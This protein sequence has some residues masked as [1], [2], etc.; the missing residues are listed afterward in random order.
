MAWDF[1][2]QVLRA[3]GASPEE[4]AEA[5]S[6]LEALIR[7]FT[8]THPPTPPR[9]LARS[10]FAYLWHTYPRRYLSGGEFRLGRVIENQLRPG[11]GPVGNC[12]GLTLLYNALAGG[13]GLRAGAVYLEEAF[14]H[15]P[16]TLSL[17]S[18]STGTIDIENIFP[19]GFDYPGH[20]DNP[21]REVWGEAEL[22]AEV[23]TSVGNGLLEAGDLRGAVDQ[24]DRALSLCPTFYKALV[25]RAIALGRLKGGES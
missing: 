2:T 7:R 23:Y 9:A 13:L 16:H 10:L 11:P 6:R 20:R 14:G 22:V 8:A 15:G 21:L 4:A 3:S 24:Y 17:L 25:N 12:L 19:E 1:P 5:L 18:L